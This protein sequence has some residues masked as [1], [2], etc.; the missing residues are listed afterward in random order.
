MSFYIFFHYFNT[1]YFKLIYFSIFTLKRNF[2]LNFSLE[3]LYRVEFRTSLKE[4]SVEIR[5]NL[6]HPSFTSLIDVS[7]HRNIMFLYRFVAPKEPLISIALL[8]LVSAIHA[9]DDPLYGVIL[10]RNYLQRINSL[11]KRSI[12]L[13][14]ILL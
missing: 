9:K 1:K 6:K 8:R 5:K 7:F 14:F 4:N 13:F 12:Y 2:P 10:F 3:K 11:R